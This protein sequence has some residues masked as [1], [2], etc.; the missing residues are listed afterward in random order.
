MP[1]I[2]AY[3]RAKYGLDRN[4]DKNFFFVVR[5][6]TTYGLF[7]GTTCSYKPIKSFTNKKQAIALRNELNNWTPPFS[8]HSY[9]IW[10]GKESMES[11]CHIYGAGPG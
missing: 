2:P 6:T 9:H 8:D 7:S 11:A 3:I 5:K 1:R 4:K 10:D